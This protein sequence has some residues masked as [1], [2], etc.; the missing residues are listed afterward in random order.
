MTDKQILRPLYDDFHRTYNIDAVW[1]RNEYFRLW[2]QTVQVRG[3]GG[4]KICWKQHFEGASIH[5]VFS[6]EFLVNFISTVWVKKFP[7]WGCLTFSPNGWEFLVWI[8]HTYVCLFTLDYKFLSNY[9]Q[10]WQSYA[11]L[12]ATTQFAPYVENVHHCLKRTRAFSDIFSKQ[13][14]IF[15]PNFI[16]LLCVLH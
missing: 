3:P 15:G 6:Y 4:I 5:F 9:L 10:F 7:S 11:I 12:S 14:G 16:P 8:L 13:L 2:N 1:D